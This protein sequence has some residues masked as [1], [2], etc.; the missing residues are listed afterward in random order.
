MQQMGA[1]VTD[2]QILCGLLDLPTGSSC[3]HLIKQA[4]AVT[5]PIQIELQKNEE[6]PIAQEIEETKLH[7]NYKL[8]RQM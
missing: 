3:H 5:G 8:A 1:G 6:E 7:D 4:E 2:V